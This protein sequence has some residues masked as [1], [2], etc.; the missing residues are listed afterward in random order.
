MVSDEC[1][2]CQW[3]QTCADT[4]VV[5]GIHDVCPS[6]WPVPRRVPGVCLRAVS[7]TPLQG[8]THHDAALA[9][10]HSMTSTQQTLSHSRHR[11]HSHYDGWPCPGS[12][13]AARHLSRYVTS[14]WGQL[15]L[16]IPLWWGA[17]STSQRP[18][19]PGGFAVKAGMVRVWVAG[20]T[21]WSHCY[22]RARSE[23]FRDKELI[24]KRYINAFVIL[25]FY[26]NTHTA[27]QHVSCGQFKQQL[28]VSELTTKHCD[29]LLLC[30]LEIL[31]LTYLLT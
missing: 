15:S 16:D 20:K 5:W 9:P 30:V 22:T 8:C 6:E 7:N 29:C 17:I 12:I 28:F 3:I 23:R 11:E 10:S 31:L 24:I 21:V 18:V 27:E 26:H 19:M 2:K 13:T 14:H 25:Y 4:K 1:T